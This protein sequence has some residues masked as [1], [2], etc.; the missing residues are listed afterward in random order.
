VNVNIFKYEI[1]ARISGVASDDTGWQHVVVSG[2]VPQSNVRYGNLGVGWALFNYR[3]EEGA[4]RVTTSIWLML[5]L[6]T[7]VDRPP[8]WL[9]D[10]D[11]FVC[12]SRDNTITNAAWVRLDI[13]TFQGHFHK[14]I[15]ECYIL[16]TSVPL[17]RWHRSYS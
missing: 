9:V 13:D 14:D 15:S 2:D 10:N 4:S 17:T 6:W 3:V 16:N 12:D 1:L 5:L 8:D 11:V 7:N